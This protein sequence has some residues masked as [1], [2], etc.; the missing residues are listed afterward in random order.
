VQQQVVA[1][2]SGTHAMSS[3]AEKEEDRV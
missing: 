1:L 2:L 3:S